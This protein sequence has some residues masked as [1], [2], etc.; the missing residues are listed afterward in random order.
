MR[1]ILKLVSNKNAVNPVWTGGQIGPWGEEANWSTGFSS[2][3]VQQIFT[4][5]CDFNHTYIGY[6][7]KLQV[8]V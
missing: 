5:F 3:T 6:L 1:V 7:P 2:E 4:K 8:E